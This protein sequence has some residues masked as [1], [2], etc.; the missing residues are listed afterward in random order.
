MD[1]FMTIRALASALLMCFPQEDFL[2]DVILITLSLSICC[3]EKPQQ[4]DKNLK[5]ILRCYFAHI[6]QHNYLQI[7]I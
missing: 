4:R 7:N 3:N 1:I 6:S 5:L 2:R